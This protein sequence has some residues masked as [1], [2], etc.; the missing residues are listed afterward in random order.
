MQGPDPIFQT[1]QKTTE[2]PVCIDNVEDMPSLMQRQIPLVQR[3]Q[4]MV[5][6]PQIQFIDNEVHAPF[7]MQPAPEMK[8]VASTFVT[9]Y[10]ASATGVNDTVATAGVNLDI[11]GLMNPLLSIT[12]GRLQH[13]MSLT[14]HS[15]RGRVQVL[16]YLRARGQA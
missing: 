12:G 11:T 3:V 16:S 4:K 15:A 9:E 10:I 7:N 6:V 13:L 2:V 1:V 14:L 5:E 8:H